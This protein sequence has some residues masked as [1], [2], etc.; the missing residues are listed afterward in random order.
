MEHAREPFRRL[1]WGGRI[2]LGIKL[3]YTLFIAVLVPI[4]WEESTLVGFLYFCNVALLATLAALWLENSLLAGMQALAIL[5]PHLLWQADFLIQLF[6]GIKV[7]GPGIAD[8]VFDTKFPLLSRALAL[9]HVWLLYLL[10]WLL[11]RLGYDRRAL[12]AQTLFAWVILL[13]SFSLTKE[14]HGPAGNVNDIYG[15]SAT[16]PQIWMAPW[17]WLV[18]LMIFMPVCWYVPLH[19]LFRKVFGPPK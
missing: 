16:E 8:Y 4:Y 7:F 18:L 11:W 3:L 5:W 17:L 9:H 6:A 15:L 2:P 10:L 13:L 14:I 12:C 1:F 19:F